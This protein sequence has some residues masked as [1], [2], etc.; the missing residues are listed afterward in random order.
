MHD[1]IQTAEVKGNEAGTRGNA[2]VK[3]GSMEERKEL[4]GVFQP[5]E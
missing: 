3:Y 2:L 1:C 4:I 5:T